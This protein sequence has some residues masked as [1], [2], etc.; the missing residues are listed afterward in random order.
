[1][2]YSVIIGSAGVALL[3]LAFFLT[4][5]K[6]M[7]QDSAS[8]A[9]MNIFGAGLSCYASALIGFM[10]FVVLEAAWCIVAIAGLVK[11]VGKKTAS[12]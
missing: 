9:I 6:I 10:P 11:V 1:M 4:L 12:R 7:K 2:D 8:Y 5:F 3:L